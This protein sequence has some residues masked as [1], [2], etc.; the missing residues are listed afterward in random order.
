MILFMPH[1]MLSDALSTEPTAMGEKTL[2][3]IPLDIDLALH[4][5]PGPFL[6]LDFF[7]FEEKFSKTTMDRHA[8]VL[9]TLVSVIYS[10]WV[11]YCAS[12]NNI[13][14]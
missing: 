8:P 12:Y 2:F 5:F 9:A 13:C 11:E 7:L 1:L 4:G 10:V 14:E 6:L 3:R